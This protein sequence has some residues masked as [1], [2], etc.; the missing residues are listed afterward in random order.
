M[1]RGDQVAFYQ[2]ENRNYL[3]SG[4]LVNLQKT[5][6]KRTRFNRLKRVRKEFFH[7]NIIGKLLGSY[8]SGETCLSPGPQIS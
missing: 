1:L 5:V 6:A 7:R 4:L 3:K 2:W 8:H